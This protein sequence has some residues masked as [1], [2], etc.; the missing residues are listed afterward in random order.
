MRSTRSRRSLIS[1]TASCFTDGMGASLHAAISLDE[2]R[3]VLEKAKAAAPLYPSKLQTLPQA[4][5]WSYGEGSAFIR[6]RIS[7][8]DQG[9]RHEASGDDW[10]GDRSPGVGLGGGLCQYD[11]GQHGEPLG[12]CLRSHHVRQSG[13]ESRYP[14]LERLPG[15]RRGRHGKRGPRGGYANAEQALR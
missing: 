1:W 7:M 8:R 15:E 5:R 3:K 2:G 14:R 11:D 12:L 13:D 6:E 10:I 9:G 4:S